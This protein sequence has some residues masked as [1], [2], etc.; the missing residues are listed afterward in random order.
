MERGLRKSLYLN[1]N[2]TTVSDMGQSDSMRPKSTIPARTLLVIGGVFLCLAARAWVL[3]LWVPERFQARS[4]VRINRAIADETTTNTAA[5]MGPYFIQTEFEI[6]QSEMVLDKTMA[7]LGLNASLTK[8]LKRTEPVNNSEVRSRLKQ[9]LSLEVLPRDTNLVGITVGWDDPLLA[10]TIA[11]GIAD[12]Y[13]NLRRDQWREL[14]AART[15]AI[16]AQLE[17]LQTKLRTAQSET[18]QLQTNLGF[19]DP[20]ASDSTLPTSAEDPRVAEQAI[21]NQAELIK[22]EHVATALKALDH[23]QLVG[24]LPT[25]LPDQLMISMVNDLN[26]SQ[27]ELAGL[28]VDH[29][30]QHPEVLRAQASIAD[31]RRRIDGRADGI[32]AGLEVRVASLKTAVEIA[33]SKNE[34][35][36]KTLKPGRQAAPLFG[37]E[38]PSGGV[39]KNR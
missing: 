31:L 39:G 19:T 22:W 8:T 25:V 16:H 13:A 36:K 21:E 23:Q 5:R 7:A 6:I 29:G 24:A 28:Q 37:G 2:A 35:R 11:N 12:A 4:A 1:G 33:A 20:A 15:N 26:K 34:A 9:S 3:Y 27:L 14:H 30:E 32:L 17:E 18:W 38:E 10:A